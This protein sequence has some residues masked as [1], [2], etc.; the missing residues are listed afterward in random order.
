MIST[1]PIDALKLDMDFIRNAFRNGR[2][3]RLLELII[4]IADYLKVPVVAEGVE[5][6]EQFGA[7]QE[8][9]CDLVQGFYFSKPVPPEEFESFLIDRKALG[10]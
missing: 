5:T 1:L 4:D 3:T 8:M 7:L 2:D 6:E 10:D 9:G